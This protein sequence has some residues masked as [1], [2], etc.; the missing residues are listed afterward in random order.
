MCGILGALSFRGDIADDEE[1][2]DYGSTLMR[3]RGPDGAGSWSDGAFCSLRFRRLAILDLSA[4]AT[5]PMLTKDGR[6]ALVYNGELY[7]YVELRAELASEGVHFHSSGDTEVVLQ[8]LARWGSAALARM[9]GMFALALYDRERRTLL[10]ARDHAGI[11]PLYY[12]HTPTR[13][14]FA[15]QYDQLLV[16]PAGEDLTIDREALGLY[17]R[18]GYT[19]AP[20]ALFRGTHQVEAGTILH[21]DA[22]GGTRVERYFTFPKQQ[23]PSLSGAEANEAV[24]AAI[25][26]AVVRQLRSDVP[27]GVLLSGGID[28]PLVAAKMRLASSSPI[29]AFTISTGGDLLD[30]SNDA[31]AYARKLGLVHHVRTIAGEGLPE[32]LQDVV[33][34]AGEPMGDYSILP[35]LLVS[36]FAREQVTV[37]LSGDGGDELFWGYVARFSQ[38]ISAAPD[39]RRPH[40]LRIVERQARKRLGLAAPR[41]LSWRNVG[42]WYRGRH[43]FIQSPWRAQIFPDAPRW[44][45][46]FD[47]FDHEGHGKDETAQWLRWNEFQGHLSRVLLKV[48]RASMHESLEVRVPLL[49][50]EVVKTAL[51][52]DWRSCLDIGRRAGKLPLRASLARHLDAQTTEK[53]GFAVPIGV[54]LRGPLRELFERSIEGRQSCFDVPL[55]SGPL[56]ALWRAHLEG[57]TDQGWALWILFALFLWQD[58][59]A[60]LRRERATFRL[61]AGGRDE[62]HV[63]VAA[64]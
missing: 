64:T 14:V 26:A 63:T 34:S 61:A 36:R 47:L 56:R 24:D 23:R 38:T 39:F 9:N 21:V 27:T 33:A 8:A 5:Q 11:K 46:S 41:H 13:F 48:D 10:L 29:Q 25:S 43:T 50:L 1:A 37:A 52:V 30:E 2:L 7:N 22:Q 19:P 40:G 55:Q 42:M 28:S 57:G 54:W 51:Q 15:S 44:P 16:H 49:D 4:A 6:L 12:L 31:A 3:R 60:V 18:L 59:I 62:Q 35:T 53:K 58:R 17:L 20:Y 45:V 32:L